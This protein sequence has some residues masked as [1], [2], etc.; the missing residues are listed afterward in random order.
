MIYKLNGPTQDSTREYISCTRKW[1]FFWN[2]ALFWS[3]SAQLLLSVSWRGK[4]ISK[5]SN[6]YGEQRDNC[7]IWFCRVLRFEGGIQFQV[8]E[9]STFFVVTILWNNKTYSIR[10]AV[11]GDGQVKKTYSVLLCITIRTLNESSWSTIIFAKTKHHLFKVT[12]EEKSC[13]RQLK[14]IFV[15]LTQNQTDNILR[16]TEKHSSI[17]GL[18]IF[19]VQRTELR[20]NASTSSAK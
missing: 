9:S 18:N 16:C 5:Q 11:Q 20:V 17:K 7:R 6:S 10:R 12:L 1:S 14:N 2:F 3:W 13:T 15:Y 19:T 4:Y 8:V